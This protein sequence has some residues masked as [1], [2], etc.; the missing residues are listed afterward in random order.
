MKSSVLL[1]LVFVS[2]VL[3]IQA[4]Q[5]TPVQPPTTG[6]TPAPQPSPIFPRGGRVPQ[7]LGIPSGGNIIPISDSGPDGLALQQLI[8]QTYAQPLYRKPTENELFAI[9]PRP[10]TGNKYRDFLRR[11]NTGM[12]RLVVDTG[13]AENSKVITAT[14]DCVKY[15]MPGAGNSFSFRTRNY[16]IKGL[17]DLTYSDNS[18]RITGMMMHGILVN[19][20][21]VPI[22]EVFLQTRGVQYPAAFQPVTDFETARAK[23][24]QIVGGVERDGF[25]YK[26]SLPANENA[27]YVLRAVAYRGKLFRTVRGV[28]YNEMDFDKRRDVI[29]AFRVVYRDTDGSLTIVWQELSNVDSPKLKP[30]VERP[31][32]VGGNQKTASENPPK[33]QP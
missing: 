13:C 14:D 3:V 8:V 11:P 31:S 16:R 5:T 32:S 10:G 20:G 24:E 15:T 19:L 30:P 17:A 28:S 33:P 1:F 27:T 6:A 12:F 23:D 26:R 25:L 18:L 22:E 2:S 29:I 7:T 21:D 9:A 4:R